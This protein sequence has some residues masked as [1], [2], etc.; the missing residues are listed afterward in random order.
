MRTETSTVQ[1]VKLLTAGVCIQNMSV[2]TTGKNVI[3]T[4]SPRTFYIAH[5][6]RFPFV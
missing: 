4:F 6:S 1:S 3:Y 5:P 2:E